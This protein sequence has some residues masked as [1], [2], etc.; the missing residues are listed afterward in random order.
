MV[1]T[2]RDRRE[3]CNF[4]IPA[5]ELAQLDR[6]FLGSIQFS[7]GCPY[8]CEFCDIPALYGR[9]PRFKTPAQICA[10]LDKLLACGCSG[11]AGD[12]S[13]RIRDR[14]CGGQSLLSALSFHAR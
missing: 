2:T 4:P 12:W 6:Y 14:I 10:E 9:N 8:Q 5:Y 3:L 13:R 7:S 11:A 1:L